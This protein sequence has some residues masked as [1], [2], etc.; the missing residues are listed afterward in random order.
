MTAIKKIGRYCSTDN[1]G[2]IVNDSDIGKVGP[3]FHKVIRKVKDAYLH[4]LGEDIHS[5]YIR[6]SIPRGLG[7]MGV[8]DLDTIAVT[9]KK[10]ND[11]DLH[12]VEQTEQEINDEFDCV[13]GV[14][15]SFY[16][17]NDILDTSFFSIIPFMLKTHSICVFGKDVTIDLPNFKAD[18]R[19]ANEHLVNLRSQIQQAQIDLTGNEDPED[20]KDCCIWIM[21]I[22]IRA[23]LALVMINRVYTRD[24][25]P[26]YK[27]FSVN[28]PEQEPLMRK[29]LHYAIAP[30]TNADSLLEFINNFGIWLVKE[31]G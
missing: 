24:L 10:S 9:N 30:T 14:E 2:Y 25:Y 17:I 18:K 4:Y 29:A 12:W 15:L 11:L 27:L 6:G 13:N 20:I 23:G 7:L 8:S 1:E 19:L 5:I 28:F 22:V 31:A 21:K 3:E 26:A 16:Y